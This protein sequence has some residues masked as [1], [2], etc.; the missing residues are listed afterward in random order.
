MAVTSHH[1][2]TFRL[3][4]QLTLRMATL[5]VPHLKRS[6][7]LKHFFREQRIVSDALACHGQLR[8]ENLSHMHRMSSS[9]AV[10]LVASSH[11]DHC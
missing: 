9:W 8:I 3:A 7:E 4:L 1:C 6:M 10:K 11:T 2:R 5:K